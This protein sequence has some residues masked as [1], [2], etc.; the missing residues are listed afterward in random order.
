MTWSLKI[1]TSSH[2]FSCLLTCVIKN[3]FFWLLHLL[4]PLYLFFNNISDLWAWKIEWALWSWR[5]CDWK[6]VVFHSLLAYHLI[7]SWS[8]SLFPCWPSKEFWTLC[9][10][11]IGPLCVH[12]VGWK[13]ND[14]RCEYSA[15]FPHGHHYW[16]WNTRR[17]D[18]KWRFLSTTEW[19]S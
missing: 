1:M 16:S 3:F 5:I 4:W 10:L 12:D 17:D 8:N 9:L 13:P 19:S 15:R 14:D 6:H 7:N 18:A 11:C 2:S